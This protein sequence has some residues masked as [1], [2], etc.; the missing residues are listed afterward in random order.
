MFFTVFKFPLHRREHMSSDSPSSPD[1]FCAPS[2][3][4][5]APFNPTDA[6]AQAL[7]FDSLRL[8]PGD[9][10][11]DLGCGDGRFLVYASDEM[12]RRGGGG[13]AGAGA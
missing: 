8:S 1:R 13:G 9:V 10:L 4:K 7:A 11:Y 12:A 3:S 5:L 2:S 6:S